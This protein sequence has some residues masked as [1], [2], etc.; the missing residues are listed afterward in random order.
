MHSAALPRLRRPLQE[1]DKFIKARSAALAVAGGTK[2]GVM[3]AASKAKAATSMT[4]ARVAQMVD[5][6]FACP[7]DCEAEAGFGLVFHY[8]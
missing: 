1:S 2:K 5:L 6:E 3:K 7:M 8:R 4:K